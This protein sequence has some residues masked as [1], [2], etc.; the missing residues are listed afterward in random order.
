M[1]LARGVLRALVGAVFV[2]AAAGKIADDEGTRIAPVLLGAGSGI[3]GTSAA[4]AEDAM[5][6]LELLAGVA[7]WVGAGRVARGLLAIVLGASFTAIAL[8]MPDGVRCGCF[9]VLGELPS[10]AAH[11]A[12]ASGVL[13]ASAVLL[14]LDLRRSTLASDCGQ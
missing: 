3:A 2:V 11:V 14:W 9:G 5:P 1:T 10:R 13:L 4:V 6:W 8:L 12:L 7:T